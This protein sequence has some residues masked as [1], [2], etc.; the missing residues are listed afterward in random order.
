MKMKQHD[1]LN[2]EIF[3]KC[4]NITKDAYG[5]LLTDG[6]PITPEWLK[7]IILKENPKSNVSDKHITAIVLELHEYVEERFHNGTRKEL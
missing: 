6:V 5:C 7:A 2:P 4:Y 1:L 3:C